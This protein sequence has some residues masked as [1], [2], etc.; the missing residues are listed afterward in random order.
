MPKST[1]LVE[2]KEKTK[3]AKKKKKVRATK[4]TLKKVSD[5]LFQYLEACFRP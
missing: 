4:R 3:T 2:K 1:V 5:F